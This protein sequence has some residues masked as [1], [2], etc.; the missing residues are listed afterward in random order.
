MRATV[1]LLC[2]TLSQPAVA[3]HATAESSANAMIWSRVIAAAYP[4]ATRVTFADSTIGL[5]RAPRAVAAWIVRHSVED[6]VAVMDMLDRNR[7]A[8]KI[9]STLLAVLNGT[10]QKPP[11]PEPRF[12][13]LA[14]PGFNARGDVAFV[15]G[16]FTCGRGCGW[17]EG[18]V[19]ERR[20]SIWL[21]V[22]RRR[23]SVS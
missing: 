20:G 12:V 1:V 19:L 13:R 18:F 2:L 15:Y 22:A 4:T 17:D 21:V 8:F 10:A 7:H 23:Y 11:A 16:Q 14:F 3:Q 9:D 6:S 5:E